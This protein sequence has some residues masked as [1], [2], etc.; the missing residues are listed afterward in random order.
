M[1][2]DVGGFDMVVERFVVL[3]VENRFEK[4]VKDELRLAF[5]KKTPSLVYELVKITT[6][7]CLLSHIE[8]VLKLLKANRFDYIFTL[9]HL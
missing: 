5:R 1:E 6:I 4:L 8:I 7:S 3:Q 9:I 2:E